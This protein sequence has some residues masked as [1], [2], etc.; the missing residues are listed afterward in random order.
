MNGTTKLS[1]GA[2]TAWNRPRRSTTHARCC[3]TTRIALTTPIRTTMKI[4]NVTSEY[5]DGIGSSPDCGERRLLTDAMSRPLGAEH[6]RRAAGRHNVHR[7]APRRLRARELAVPARA[8]IDDARGAIGLP[9]F[10][11]YALADVEARELG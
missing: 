8:A 5:P 9:R 7:V 4:A 3:G 11:A 6:E 2:S 10:D 1:P